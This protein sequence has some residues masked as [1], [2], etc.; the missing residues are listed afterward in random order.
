MK[1]LTLVLFICIASVSAFAQNSKAEKLKQLLEIQGSGKM[2]EQV[3]RTMIE[4]YKK[5]YPSVDTKIWEEFATEMKGSEMVALVTPIYDKYYTEA[6]ID[7][8]ITFYNSPI[9]KKSVE[10][11]PV[12]MQESMSVGQEWGKKIAEKIAK[13]LKDKGY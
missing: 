12:I 10:L 2:G 13:K 7:Q 4:S 6:D 8:L 11:M 5:A 9:G 1:K 3:I